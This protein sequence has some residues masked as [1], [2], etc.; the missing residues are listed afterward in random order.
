MLKWRE[1]DAMFQCTKH[2]SK[3]MQDGTFVSGRAT[4]GM[5]R[6]PVEVSGGSVM[7]DTSTA[8]LQ[9]QDEARWNAAAASLS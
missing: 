1:K 3:Y 8:I 4:R 6:Y 7:V 5:D 9:D 2:K